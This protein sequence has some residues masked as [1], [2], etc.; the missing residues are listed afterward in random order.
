[1]RFFLNFKIATKILFSFSLVILISSISSLVGYLGVMDSDKGI[2]KLYLISD[3]VAKTDDALL[4]N[5]QLRRYEKDF[6]LNIGNSDAQAKYLK[7]FDQ[8]AIQLRNDLIE[9]E[10]L[11]D[12][13]SEI[14]DSIHPYIESSTNAVSEYIT[15]AHTVF[16]QVLEN[17]NMT[18][19]N[20][21]QLMVPYK[22]STHQMETDLSTIVDLTQKFCKVV[23]AKTKAESEFNLHTMIVVM[24]LSLFVTILLGAYI[25]LSIT[26]PIKQMR[27]LL[28]NISEGEGDLTQRLPVLSKDEVG[29][30]AQA[31]NVFVKKIQDIIEQ[32]TMNSRSVA[33]AAVELSATSTQIA[34]N[35][36]EL[37]K[38]TISIG[39]TTDKANSNIHSIASAAEEMSSTAKSVSLA[40]ENVSS[41][42]KA[43]TRN[44]HLELDVA[45]QAS[46]HAQAGKDIMDRLGTS[47]QAIGKMLEMIKDIAEQTNLLAL[48][49][50]IE[51]AT[52]GDAGKGFAVVASEVKSLAKQTAE[53][54]LEIEKQIDEIGESTDL[55][56]KA[57]YEIARVIE[58]INGI[59][60][61]VMIA[62]QEQDIAVTNIA[63]NIVGVSNAAKDVAQN[64]SESANGLSLINETIQG[65]NNAVSD[66]A[67]GIMQVKESAEELARLSE[68][69][70][71]LVGRFKVS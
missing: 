61:K 62:V 7:K 17:A 27:T 39:K 1:M 19:Q 32:V 21:N 33:A 29:E 68:M 45:S 44:S 64:V 65:A 41:S 24:I 9:V 12:S 40:V 23:F 10:K 28:I 25:A 16:K 22:K 52:A 69:M 13:I 51:A 30:V 2:A 60:R 55:A 11:S 20:S 31:F 53:A 3:L 18:S 63:H 67:T 15:G 4:L 50:T 34:S 66:T 6:L 71:K 47:T 57:I 43:V 36:M 35:T 48:N 26:S 59:S 8:V 38:Q 70:N 42:I 58:E 56:I 37:N 54:T 14:S 49:A 5:A 46:Q